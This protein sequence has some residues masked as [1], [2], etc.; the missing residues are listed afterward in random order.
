MRFIHTADL[1]IGNSLHE[2]DRI[3]E[4][5]SFFAWFKDLIVSQKAEA[6]IIAGDVF[7][8]I[9]PSNEA[10]KT[11]YEFLASLLATDCKNIIIVG[12][13][14]D[15][16]LM[17]DTQSELLKALNI[18]IVGSL[19]NHSIEDIVYELKDPDGKP[20]AI[21]AA[22]PFVREPEL[23][24]YADSSDEKFATA[25]NKALYT[26]V[27]QK[28]LELRGKREIPV[29]GTGHLY[30]ANLE[31][32]LNDSNQ[33]IESLKGH[34]IRDIVGNL[35][36]VSPDAFPTEFDYIA[37]G[38]I[39]YTTMVNKNPR[40]RYSG[41]PFVLGFDEA[42]MP[43]YVLSVDLETGKE[44]IIEKI[45]VPQTVHFKRIKGSIDEIQTFP[46]EIKVVLSYDTDSIDVDGFFISAAGKECIDASI[47]P[48]GPYVCEEITINNTNGSYYITDYSSNSIGDT[49]SGK[50]SSSGARVQIYSSDGCEMSFAV[51]AG[52]I[53]TVWQVFEIRNKKIIPV[54]KY[55]S[56][57]DSDSY[58]TEKRN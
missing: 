40:I 16:G 44:P 56:S 55:Y 47:N 43:H 21:C 52:H 8:T 20:L 2:L 5:R 36:N 33:N 7:D 41:S 30:A 29:I 34:G 54:N 14:H 25:S 26:K 1:H 50:L 28:A 17:L 45:E 51:P 15:S 32:R 24:E 22:V 10:R 9:N 4:F 18:Q 23:R 57:I 58:F 35:G 46:G 53:G 31:G 12:G 42:E 13:N 38:H 11:F 39:H 6:L 19:A 37:L 48:T 49:S 3:D 27:C